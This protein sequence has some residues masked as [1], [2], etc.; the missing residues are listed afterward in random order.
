[1]K[2]IVLIFS[3]ILIILI[4]AVIAVPFLFKGKIVQAVKDQIN[5][6]LTAKVNFSEDIGLSLIKNF[7]NLSLSIKD[8]EVI[9]TEVFEQDTLLRMD[10]FAATLDIMSVISGEEIRIKRVFLDRPQIHAI[11]LED[12]KANWDIT[13]PSDSV[14]TT[15]VEDTSASSFNIAL[16]SYEIKNADIVYDDRQG[17]MKAEVLGLNHEGNGDFTQ[18]NFLLK[19]LTTIQS[20]TYAMDGMNYL[21]Q[22]ESEMKVDINMN[23]P[24]MRFEFDENTFRI[25][26]L[27]IGLDGFIA[28]PDDNVSMDL[29]LVSKKVSFKEILSLVP[30]LYM[31]DFEQLKTDGKTAL[32]ASAK[33]VFNSDL[34]KYPAFALNLL[35]ENAMFQYPDLPE[36]LNNVNVNLDITNK[37]GVLNNTVTNL[38]KLHF[39]LGKEPF[40]ARLLLTQPMTDPYVD[41]AVNGKVN[42]DNVKKLVP[43]E[44]G[45]KLSGI[46]I[47]DVTAKG[48]VSTLSGSDYEAMEVAGNLEVQNMHYEDAALPT[49][50]DLNSMQ[51]AFNPK[52]VMLNSFDSKL[53]HSDI[54]LNGSLQNFFGYMFKEGEVLKGNLVMES[55][56]LDA[57]A[58]MSEE[59]DQKETPAPADT[60]A[61][62]ALI[63]PSNI[64]FT[65]QIKEIQKV[66]YD[67]LVINGVKGTAHVHDAKLDLNGVRLGIFDGEVEMNGS[68]DTK[69]TEQP[70]TDMKLKLAGID[71]KESYNYMNTVQKLAP[72]AGYLT[73]K[74]NAEFSLQTLLNKDMTPNLASITSL[75]F[76]KT[77]DA[78]LSNFTP[79]TALAD[80]LKLQS[81]KDISLTNTNVSFEVADGKVKLK[82]PVDFK[83]SDIS[84]SVAE[85][86]YTTFDQLINYTMKLKVPKGAF[87]TAGSNA[88]D[89]LLK[90]VNK[91]GTDLK[92]GDKLDVNVLLGG[93]VKQPKI[94]TS[95][96]DIGKEAVDQV[97]DQVKKVID[98]KKQEVVDKVNEEKQK[99]IDQASQ[100]GDALIAEAKKQ[101]EN[102]KAEAKKQGDAL[103]AE[104]DKAAAKLIADAGANPIKKEAAKRLGDKGKNE[105]RDKADKLNAEAEKKANDLISKAE[106]E[107]A[108]L[109]AEA[110]K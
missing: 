29:N 36:S 98:D 65:F 73:G 43:L 72:I 107:K 108:R 59:G 86:G 18:D 4:G 109:I 32:T 104:A 9:G 70:A 68:Y 74:V 47:S 75:G 39:E 76:F 14:D 84:V 66:L 23:M 92:A 6:Q 101:G 42:L 21:N 62:E 20:L 96:K 56:L 55:N 38:K 41:M 110:S 7:P 11:V 25:N 67:N 24:S 97:K 89:N 49:P 78:V 82:K 3:L 54:R 57:N 30:A 60:V 26:Q 83:V 46:V 50:F 100:K 17:S 90:E 10:E 106:A 99:L 8:I 45:S 69:N 48:R 28:M 34:E 5:E 31:K 52:E 85:D 53:G 103:I 79:M 81:L 1:M 44:E 77:T 13:K 71:I 16:R 33:G 19:T 27:E 22:V 51:M 40:D 88:L 102:I 80:K 91:T 63:I 58:F 2:K 61:M 37:D 105:A 12:G 95:L 15:A 94:T 87:G 93:T 64:D 35:I